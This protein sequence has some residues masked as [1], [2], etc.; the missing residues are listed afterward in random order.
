MLANH[1]LCHSLPLIVLFLFRVL[2]SII[3]SIRNERRLYDHRFC[4]VQHR[5][6]AWSTVPEIC[7]RNM[8]WMN[9]TSCAIAWKDVYQF[10]SI[11]Y[12]RE[13]ITHYRKILGQSSL[14][15]DSAFAGFLPVAPQSTLA[16]L[17]QPFT[18]MHQS[19]KNIWVTRCACFPAEAEQ[20]DSPFSYQ[21]SCYKYM[22]FSWSIWC[23]GFC[24]WFCC[25]KW[26][27]NIL[28]KGCLVF[29]SIR[30]LCFSKKI[31]MLDKLCSVKSH[32]AIGQG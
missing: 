22:S 12:Y 9:W 27:Q 3:F 23:H 20:D 26:P 18:D 16:A 15:T 21:F 5:I 10:T 11:D 13:R 24:I 25:L 14:S 7:S 2:P 30:S 8:G 4:F 29:L 6:L 28:Q 32:R 1:A 17:W 19:S 31:P